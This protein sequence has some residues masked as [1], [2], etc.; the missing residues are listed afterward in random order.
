MKRDDVILV[1]ILSV[2]FFGGLYFVSDVSAEPD[3]GI[4]AKRTLLSE[5]DTRT[6]FSVNIGSMAAAR[7]FVA[8]TRTD[9]CTLIYNPSASFHLMVGTWS[10]FTDTDL[11]FFV[12]KGSGTF[13]DCN[14]QTFYMRYPPGAS[15]ETVRGVLLGE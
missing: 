3:D 15:S 9:R 4:T 12:N 7:A 11:W 5:G 14:H 6:P 2:L 8:N 13:S 10:A 1:L